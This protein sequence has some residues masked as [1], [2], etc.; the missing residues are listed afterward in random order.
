[1]AAARFYRRELLR[2]NVGWPVDQVRDRGVGEVLRV[3]SPWRIGYAP[4]A[5]TL[6][7]SHMREQGYD[8]RTLIRAGLSEWTE[9]GTAVDVFRNQ[10]MMLTRDERLDP[11]GFVGVGPGAK[12][13]YTASPT[14]LIHRPSNALAGIEEQIDILTDGAFVVVVNDPLD[15]V[16][17]ENLGRLAGERWAGIPMC[18]AQMSSAQAKTLYRYTVTDTVIVALDGDQEWRRTAIASHP[19]LS[20]FYKRVRAVEIPDGQSASS[21][22]KTENGP[23]R[24]YDAMVSTRPL[25]D[26]KPSRQ[27]LPELDDPSPSPTGP[28]L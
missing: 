23:R 3:D 11:V 19:D 16:A 14:T 10:L 26:Y 25:E 9:E 6:L 21:L 7:T 24:L 2:A 4:D 12:P 13:E 17:I 18:G 28:S 8:F 20:Y 15:A 22:L 1:M 5:F 27:Q